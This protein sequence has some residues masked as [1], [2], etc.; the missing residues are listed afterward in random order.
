[1]FETNSDRVGWDGRFDG[2]PQTTQV[3]V[4][5]MEGTGV[6]NNIYLRK[7]SSLLVR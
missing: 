5:V 3:V 1:M 7:G 4:W 2:I 6:D